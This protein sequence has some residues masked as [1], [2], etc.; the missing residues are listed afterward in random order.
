MTIKRLGLEFRHPEVAAFLQGLTDEQAAKLPPLSL[1]QN[2]VVTQYWRDGERVHCDEFTASEASGVQAP[3]I[4]LKPK[5]MEHFNPAFQHAEELEKF[6][7]QPRL[8]KYYHVAGGDFCKSMQLYKWNLE[9]SS[10]F[11][12]PLHFCE[13]AIR[14]AVS[15]TFFNTYGEDWP[16]HNGLIR[17]LD[18]NFGRKLLVE[19]STKYDRH[20]NL[21][22]KVV[23]ELN[24]VFWEQ[25]FTRRWHDFWSGKI[26]CAFPNRSKNNADDL[27]KILYYEIRSVRK[28]RNRIAHH[29]PI[30]EPRFLK[31]MTQ[32]LI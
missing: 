32:F 23:S 21:V 12:V 30:F 28:L 17:S 24:F 11:Q 6:F 25:I 15:D 3:S 20:P 19:V 14:N 16:W 29:E 1:K 22:G 18:K 5:E 4:D 8:H 10:A 13:I 26:Q 27:R 7:S 31:N 9:I 2:G